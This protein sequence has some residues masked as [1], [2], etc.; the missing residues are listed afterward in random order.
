MRPTPARIAKA[1]TEGDRSMM[2]APSSSPKKRF[3]FAAVIFAGALL[4]LFGSGATTQARADDLAI[5]NSVLLNP[6]DPVPEIRF[7][8]Y[9]CD[10][11]C[12]DH[13][14]YR[15]CGEV[16]RCWHECES[17]RCEHGCRERPP[18]WRDCRDRS[19]PSAALLNRAWWETMHH[20][21]HQSH[22]WHDMTDEWQK[23]MEK[24]NW[25]FMHDHWEYV[26]DD[27]SDHHGDGHDHDGDHHD[28]DH[29]DGD[30][31]DGDHHDGDHHDDG[32]H[33]GGHP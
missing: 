3:G 5:N 18:C 12:G 21:D 26:K 2:R 11:E 4:V 22:E 6:F 16:R 14:C 15:G 20:Y 32:R 31:Q 28:G 30:H 25:R 7:S 24:Y 1:I 17:W 29:H 13:R 8:R 33:D 27:A 10:D 9:G 23:V 19:G